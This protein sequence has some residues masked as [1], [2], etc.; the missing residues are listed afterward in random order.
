MRRQKNY[1]SAS[2][3]RDLLPPPDT[4]RPSDIAIGHVAP[5]RIRYNV[6]LL[7]FPVSCLPMRALQ[8]PPC[9]LKA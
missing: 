5:A 2:R 7:R 8:R 1:S 4:P 6:R 9:R 3:R